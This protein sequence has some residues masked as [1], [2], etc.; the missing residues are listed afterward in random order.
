MAAGKRFCLFLGFLTITTI[1]GNPATCSEKTGNYDSVRPV[2]CTLPGGGTLS[3]TFSTFSWQR[4]EMVEYQTGVQASQFSG[5]SS[6]STASFD[7]SYSHSLT[8][9]CKP[10]IT[11]F[12]VAANSF[13]Q[14]PTLQVLEFQDCPITSIPANAFPN[15]FLDHLIFTGAKIDSIDADAF[16]GLN[17][18]RL[19]IPGAVGGI[20]INSALTAGL[21]ET[22]FDNL[23]SMEY[24]AVNGANL[25]TLTVGHVGSLANLKY[26]ILKDNALT[27]ITTGI[28]TNMKSLSYVD[29]SNNKFT[30]TCNDLWFLQ[31]TAEN[32]INLLGGPLC[33]TPA[34][35]DTKRATMYYSEICATADVCGNTVGVAMGSSCMALYQLMSFI[36]L[37]IIL[38]LSCLAL[39]CICK[40]RKELTRVQRRMKNKRASSWNRVQ[41]AM[42]QRSGAKQK[43]PV[44]K[45]GWI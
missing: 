23:T 6:A 42:K 5:F 11:S 3:N 32:H 41:E 44:G 45:N 8:I 16:I 37:L 27:N 22:V 38:V 12:T 17:I 39:G 33:G 36:L 34:S 7:S 24:L 28:F 35:H 20:T 25:N 26:L 21:P 13:S 31:Y 14:F 4:L 2:R 10:G 40:T 30:C 9:I 43:P 29:L 1:Q 19:S 15:H 18:S